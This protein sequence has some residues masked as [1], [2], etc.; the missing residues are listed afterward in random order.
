MYYL[1]IGLENFR[2]RYSAN[3]RCKMHVHAACSVGVSLTSGK[4]SCSTNLSHETH[5]LQLR[6]R[7]LTW[8]PSA[9][10]APL[11]A[12]C[13]GAPSLAGGE[14]RSGAS[15]PPTAPRTPGKLAEPRLQSAGCNRIRHKAAFPW[16]G[17]A[18]TRRGGTRQVGN[19]LDFVQ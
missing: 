14:E 8:N 5:L 6:R 1:N 3:R 18:G 2:S 9:Q 17:R 4:P 16:H 19:V 11:A 12:T 10:S 15:P 7:L 13:V